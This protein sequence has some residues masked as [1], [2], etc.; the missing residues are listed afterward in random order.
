MRGPII[1]FALSAL[2]LCAAFPAMARTVTGGNGI[3]A[4]VPDGWTAEQYDQP[5]GQITLISPDKV[6]LVSV[7]I[8]LETGL[9]GKALSEFFSQGVNGSAPEKV[10]GQ[11]DL[12]SFEAV[13]DGMALVAFTSGGEAGALIFMELG[14]TSGYA[15][16]L[17]LIRAG[18]RSDDSAVQK[19]LDS[20]K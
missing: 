19:I 13:I 20:L 16:E 3:T 12:Y 18:L 5:D 8:V 1:I 9:S 14:D 7:Q 6:C 10:S 2:C 17:R 4:T 15:K 11:D